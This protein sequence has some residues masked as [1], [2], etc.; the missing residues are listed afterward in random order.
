MKNY[1]V[2]KDTIYMD[3]DEDLTEQEH[4]ASCDINVMIRNAHNGLQVR[5]AEGEPVY[6]FDDTTMTGLQHRI[7]KQKLEEELARVSEEH[8]FSESELAMM[9]EKVAAKFKFKKKADQKPGANDDDKTTTKKPDKSA[10]T[11]HTGQPP[12]QQASKTTVE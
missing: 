3:P 8:E 6:G 1:K 2:P 4:A 12:K 7:Q 9:P 10:E 11:E 5:G